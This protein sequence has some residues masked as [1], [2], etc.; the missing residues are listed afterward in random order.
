M[1]LT[2]S[3]HALRRCV[4]ASQIIGAAAFITTDSRVDFT[5]SA[6]VWGVEPLYVREGGSMPAI[7][8]LA[9]ALRRLPSPKGCTQSS[10]EIA[11]CQLPF[12]Q[13]SDN[14]HLP[15]ERLGIRQVEKV[16]TSVL[17]CSWVRSVFSVQLVS[18]P[19]SHLALPH[20]APLCCRAW[21][22]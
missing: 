8:F 7:P 13:A 4:A 11:V 19:V 18:V 3:R 22:C 12:G 10:E 14:A 5:V 21:M 2:G 17:R 6:Q 20:I 9:D 1:D 16:G 15:N